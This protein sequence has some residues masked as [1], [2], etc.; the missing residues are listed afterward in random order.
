MESIQKSQYLDMRC[1][2]FELFLS[3]LIPNQMLDMFHAQQH[4]RARNL[5]VHAYTIEGDGLFNHPIPVAYSPT[6]CKFAFT[7]A[8]KSLWYPKLIH[9][10]FL[11]VVASV[12]SI[13]I[14][15]LSF[16]SAR[17]GIWLLCIVPLVITGLAILIGTSN[18]KANY[19]G[20]F[21]IAMGAFPQGP[22]LLTWV[23]KIT[24]KNIQS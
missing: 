5:I 13:G 9:Q 1:K 21:L 6:L 18:T 11:K 2:Q 7:T 19:A 12:F 23:S 20:V 16:K 8:Q 3:A 15:Y 17:R 14:A 24:S 10:P 4:D 22:I